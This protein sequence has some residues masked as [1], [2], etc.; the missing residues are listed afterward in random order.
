M[1]KFEKPEVKELEI[2]MTFAGNGWGQHNKSCPAR[3]SHIIEQ[4]T[5]GI[6]KKED[7]TS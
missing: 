5:C 2:K 1:K 7:P 6:Y 4:C 3:N